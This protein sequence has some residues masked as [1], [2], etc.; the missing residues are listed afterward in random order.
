MPMILN[1]EQTMLKDTAREFCTENAPI[2]QLRK[3]RDDDNPDGFDRDTWS[4]MAELGWP[5]IP[6]PEEHGGLAF[7]Y[8]GLGVVTE[9]TG[10]NLTASPLFASVWVG[11]TAINLGGTESMKAALL[12]GVASGELLLALALEESHRH[13]PYGIA[14]TATPSGDGYAL[15]GSK[16][17]VLDGN[18]ADRLIVAARTSGAPGER[19]GITL[20]LVDAN[21]PGIEIT[22][23]EDDRQ[24]QCGEHRVSRRG[25]LRGR[26]HRGAG[27][28]CRRP[29]RDARHRPHRHL[30]GDA[31]IGPSSVSTAPCST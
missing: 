20:F 29:R 2:A 21:A 22:A 16:T 18:V 15:S 30:G 17:F 9:E 23:D 5:G 12:P 27:P 3:L 6:F 19:H 8:K 10:R 24:P 26:D 14:T 11:G 25:G 7:G 13:D 4:S 31:R 28:R 1:E